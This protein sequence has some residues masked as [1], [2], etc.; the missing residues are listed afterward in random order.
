MYLHVL[1]RLE[2]L[3][4]DGARVGQ[5]ARRVHVEDVLLQVAIVAVEL[6]ALGARGLAGLTVSEAGREGE[7]V[8]LAGRPARPARPGP[9]A[10]PAR[11]CRR[12]LAVSLVSR[13][14]SPPS[15]LAL[16]LSQQS[17]YLSIPYWVW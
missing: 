17:P 11:S 4:A 5:L 9:A 12:P 3:A 13:A 16:L 15:R 2:T 6:A 10:R 1:A 14:L 8:R 7:A